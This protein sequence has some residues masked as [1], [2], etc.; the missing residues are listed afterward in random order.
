MALAG[1]AIEIPQVIPV[2]ILGRTVLFPQSVM[3]LYIFEKRYKRMLADILSDQRMFVLANR[4]DQQVMPQKPGEIPHMIATAGLI[5]LSSLNSD[6]S[7]NIMLQGICRVR[8]KQIVQTFPYKKVEVARELTPETPTTL[9]FAKAKEDFIKLLE[10]RE[11]YGLEFSKDAKNVFRNLKNIN[12][13]SDLAAHAF[14]KNSA[15]RQKLLETLCP[16]KRFLLLSRFIRQEINH[17]QL[18]KDIQEGLDDHDIATN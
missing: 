1:A 11:K 17:L 9:S 7:S 14:C 15:N 8:I 4:N 6:G 2:M 5:R 13:L 16:E 18:G 10:E 3:P 12:A